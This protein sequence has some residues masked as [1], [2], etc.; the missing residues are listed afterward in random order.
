MSE[1]E[2]GRRAMFSHDAEVDGAITAAPVEVPDRR[3]F[4]ARGAALGAGL[5]AGAGANSAL[6]ADAAPELP[7]W[8]KTP[9]APFRT[10]GTPSHFEEPVKRV[11]SPGYPKISPGT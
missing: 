7:T 4:L 8:S 1:Y 10:Y 9:G 6:A 2:D 5:V 3:R 11:L